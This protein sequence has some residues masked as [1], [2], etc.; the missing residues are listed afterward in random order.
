MNTPAGHRTSK[1][2]VLFVVAIAVFVFPFM[3]SAV[4]IALPTIGEELSVEVTVLIPQLFL[5]NGVV[6]LHQ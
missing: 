3:A 5:M 6:R 2:V 4:N 1:G